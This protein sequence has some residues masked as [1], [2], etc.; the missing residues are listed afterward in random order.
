MSLLSYFRRLV[1]GDSTTVRVDSY[2]SAA[3]ERVE[4]TDV[5]ALSTAWA[6]VNLRAGIIGSLPLVVY[7][8]DAKGNRGIARD[9]GLYRLLH[10]S[11][12]DEQTSL[13]FW[14]GAAASLDL[15]GNSVALKTIGS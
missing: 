4:E 12:N 11:P 15:K 8:T 1:V 9:H 5:L 10:N 14:E 13:D 7:R 2:S 3:G 6:C